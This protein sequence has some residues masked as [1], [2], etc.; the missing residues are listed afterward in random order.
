MDLILDHFPSTTVFFFSFYF[1]VCICHNSE[2][3]NSRNL[4]NTKTTNSVNKNTEFKNITSSKIFRCFFSK[5]FNIFI[6]LIHRKMSVRNRKRFTFQRSLTYIYIS[7]LCI[8]Y[9]NVRKFFVHFLEFKN[10]ENILW[11]GDF[12]P[13]K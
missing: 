5:Y 6:L 4:Q 3:H 13:N 2:K 12:H 11:K 10:K 9:K 1:T 8:M 7:L